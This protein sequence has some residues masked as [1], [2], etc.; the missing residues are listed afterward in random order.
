MN[1]CET[2]DDVPEMSVE[3]AWER[4]AV[5]ISV[6]GALERARPS[7]ETERPLPSGL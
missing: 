2:P 7:Q 5:S 6:E 3:E 1:C 4:R